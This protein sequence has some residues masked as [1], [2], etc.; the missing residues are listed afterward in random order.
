LDQLPQQGLRQ[1]RRDAQALRRVAAPQN[2]LALPAEVAGG[3]SCRP[4]D[5]RHLLAQRLALCDQL[6][7][8]LIEFGQ[9]GAQ[10]VKR[11]IGRQ[12]VNRSSFGPASLLLAEDGYRKRRGADTIAP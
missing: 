2:D 10:F 7:Q 6:E 8:L 1:V 5:R 4:F 9:G 11:H 3:A 12:D